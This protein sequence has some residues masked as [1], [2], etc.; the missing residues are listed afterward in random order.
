MEHK[1]SVGQQLLVWVYAVVEVEADSMEEAVR[2]VEQDEVPVPSI[3]DLVYTDATGGISKR[4][5]TTHIEGFSN[6]NLT[7]E[8]DIY[9]VEVK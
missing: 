1:V 2:R 9:A 3:R 5:R 6:D 7:G 4:H 8:L